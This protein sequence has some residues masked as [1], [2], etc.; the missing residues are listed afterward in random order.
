MSEALHPI[1]LP[2]PVGPFRPMPG[3]P[4]AEPTKL[5]GKPSLSDIADWRSR[6]LDAGVNANRVASPNLA[7]QLEQASDAEIDT[8]ICS[9]LD[10][11]PS[12]PLNASIADTYPTE[13]SAGL[14]LLAKLTGSPRIWITADPDKSSSWFSAMSLQVDSGGLKLVP[15]RGD[16]PQTDPTLMLY[17]LLQR[18]LAPG[19]LPT[20]KGAVLVD[21]AAALAI[22]RCVLFDPPVR[23][24]PLAVRDHFGQ[25]THLL[26][27]PMGVKLSDV[28]DF[29]GIHHEDAVY[30]AGDFLRDAWIAPDTRLGTGELVIHPTARHLNANPD[31]CIRCGWCLE[32]CPM[33]IHPAGLLDAAQTEDRR[34]AKRYGLDRCIECGICS[35]VCPTRLPL[36]TA[37][38]G[39]KRV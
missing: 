5:I 21:A 18:R 25:K 14:D 8:V 13:I 26:S 1:E 19:N 23:E 11:D 39:L 15:L 6:L 28:C 3:T 27:V 10:T 4:T 17:T 22:G 34:A 12:V 38:Q 7:R 37:I 2:E 9:V 16:Y 30:R 20:E 29:L 36:L 32:A 24:T 33:R 35:Y 31:P